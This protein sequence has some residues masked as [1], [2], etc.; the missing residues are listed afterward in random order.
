M[1]GSYIYD[2]KFAIPNVKSKTIEIR[3]ILH[4]TINHFGVVM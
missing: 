1:L 3:K 2:I 4:A